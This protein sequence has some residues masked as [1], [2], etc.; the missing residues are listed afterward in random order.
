MLEK[1]LSKRR[2]IAAFSVLRMDVVSGEM[3]VF[4]NL[5][6]PLSI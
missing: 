4:F 1:E 3:G 6:K 2:C 5:E